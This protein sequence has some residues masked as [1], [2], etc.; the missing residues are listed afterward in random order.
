MTKRPRGVCVR[1]IV[2]TDHALVRWLERVEGVDLKE[3]ARAIVTN[4]H[5]DRMKQHPYS[6]IDLPKLGVTIVVRGGRAVSV[7]PRNKRGAA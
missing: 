2:V 1:G 4:S 6:D 7:I 5:A 3:I